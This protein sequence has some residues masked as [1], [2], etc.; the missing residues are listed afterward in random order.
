[1]KNFSNTYI[2]IFSAVMVIVV[3]ALLSAVALSLKP[4]QDK[5][6][7]T[8]TMQNILKCIGVESTAK[9]ADQLF[10][11]YIVDSYVVDPKG[12][13]VAGVQAINI[14]MAKEFEKIGKIKNLEMKMEV[15]KTSPFKK[16]MSNYVKFASVDKSSVQSKVDL[17][18]DKR[19][20][21]VYVCKKDTSKYYVFPM[22]GKG[23][24]GPIWGFIALKSDLNTVYGA[25][26]DSKDETPGLGAEINKPKFQKDF[27]GKKLY[28]NKGDFTSIQVVKG[29]AP[30]SDIH[31]VDAVSGGTITS[32][33][34]QAMLYDCLSSYETF[35]A[36]N[37]K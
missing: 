3:A 32:K 11:K 33:G 2:Y 9:N 4:A 28:D 26:F 27:A 20:L 6:V 34:V 21:P 24:W 25:V 31:G 12:N 7:R 10:K 19:L 16:F 14:N 30:Q 15:H 37:R 1:M 29:G 22:W 35:I 36:N 8:E 18:K 5:N 23:L 13:K 17:I